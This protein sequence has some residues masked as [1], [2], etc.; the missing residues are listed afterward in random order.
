LEALWAAQP[1]AEPARDL[2]RGT[3]SAHFP[4]GEP[5][6]AADYHCTIKCEKCGHKNYFMRGDLDV[7]FAAQPAAEAVLSMKR[8]ERESLS[9]PAMDILNSVI[10]GP[11]APY[12]EGQK[13][14]GRDDPR[15]PLYAGAAQPVSE[16]L[17]DE[18]ID[19]MWRRAGIANNARGA[20]FAGVAAGI[21]ALESTP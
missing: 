9:A 6:P 19:M 13:S 14:I 7:E 16:P 8:S 18:Q 15:H 1:A 11:K 17:T 21:R 4:E 10:G 20:F 3:P 12:R 5:E 2:L